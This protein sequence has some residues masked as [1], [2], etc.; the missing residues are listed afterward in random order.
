[1]SLMKRGG[2]FQKGGKVQK[3]QPTGMK[4][5]NL[6]LRTDDDEMWFMATNPRPF[7]RI[8][9]QPLSGYYRA[10]NTQTFIDE[11]FQEGDYPKEA[12]DWQWMGPDSILIQKMRREKVTDFEDEMI[13]VK[14]RKFMGVANF[15][16][17]FSGLL[18]MG[19]PEEFADE[20]TKVIMKG[21][22]LKPID[23]MK[24]GGKVSKFAQGGSVDAD[25]K[26]ILNDLKK[27]DRIVLDYTGG[28][29]S[30]EITLE[31]VSKRRVGKGKT[32]EK[33]KWTFKNPNNPKGV[34]YFAYA[35]DG[36]VP[37]FA[38]GNLAISPKAI[39]KV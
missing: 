21:R 23:F 6:I 37:R 31:F 7:G 28:M 22:E 2:R 12:I 15:A 24:E 3:V 16:T 18:N 9:Y 11:W 19:V 32:W 29:A 4:P 34:K 39:K 14:S 35:S 25:V 8:S 1:M 26:S 10:Q 38:V 36:G 20:A 5:F 17:V 27:G 30:G 13:P 33:D